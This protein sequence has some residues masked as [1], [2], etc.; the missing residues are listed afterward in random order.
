[1]ISTSLEQSKKLLELG[2]DPN[3]ADMKWFE[4]KL[5]E[6]YDGKIAKTYNENTKFEYLPAWSLDALL[7]IIPYPYVLGK[8]KGT[9]Y[10]SL[11][12]IKYSIMGNDTPLDAAYY[13]I[14]WLIENNYIEHK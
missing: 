13:M 4:Q 12:P 5:F 7:R 8:R 9:Y 1:M 6:G 10:I 2:L 14:T 11:V 3:T